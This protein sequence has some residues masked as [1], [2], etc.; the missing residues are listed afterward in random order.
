MWRGG[1]ARGLGN[2]GRREEVAYLA[3]CACEAAGLATSP[4][5]PPLSL[6]CIIPR[7]PSAFHPLLARP[8]LSAM[9]PLSHSQ[10]GPLPSPASFTQICYAN[11]SAPALA[12]CCDTGLYA[13]GRNLTFCE[14]N[15]DVLDWQGCAYWEGGIDPALAWCAGAVAVPSSGGGRGRGRGWVGW[16]VGAAWVAGVVGVGV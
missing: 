1:L 15:R 3:S 13:A 2:S 14:T 10:L 7:P 9:S 16:V 4:C 12:Q 8:P 11:S 6:L 5:T